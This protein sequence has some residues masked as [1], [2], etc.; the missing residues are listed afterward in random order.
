M[1]TQG[2][3]LAAI[4]TTGIAAAIFVPLIHRLKMP[5]SERLVWLAMAMALPMQPLAFYL[6]RVPLDHWIAAH[7]GSASTTYQWVTS[8]YAPLTEEPAKLVP[9]LIPA[10]RRDI[11]AANFVRYALAIGFGFAIGEMWLVASFV[12]RVPAFAALPF[13]L[14]GGYVGERLVTCL[15]HSALVSVSLWRLRSRF[16]LGLAGAMAL[17]WLLNFPIL[18]MAW[19]VGSLGKIFWTTTNQVWLLLFFVVS[20]A[21]LSYFTFGKFSPGRAL[22]GRRWCP[23]CA[24]DYDA[25]MFAINFVTKRYERCPHCRHWHW[26][27]TFTQT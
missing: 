4:L 1:R 16:A 20:L 24:R 14:F 15:L 27:K 11:S 26:T 21:L 5:A 9:L 13:Y 3:Y 7:L 17:H 22:F 18:L 8:F 6:V 2:I 10:I 23:E 25:P 12:A 19:N